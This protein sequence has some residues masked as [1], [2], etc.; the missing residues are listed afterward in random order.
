MAVSSTDVLVHV[1]VISNKKSI[2]SSQIRTVISNIKLA[3]TSLHCSIS[4][5]TLDRRLSDPI[6]THRQSICNLRPQIRSDPRFATHVN[7]TCLV[8]LMFWL[9]FIDTT[10]TAPI[11]SCV[12]GRTQFSKIV[13]FAGKRFLLSP[14][15]SF[16][17]FFASRLPTFSSINSRGNTCYAGYF[18]RKLR[19][20]QL[21]NHFALIRF[22]KTSV[23]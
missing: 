3:F 23:E 18:V 6:L 4:N 8:W 20:F 14:P 5:Y 9:L 16:L 12:R 19:W 1:D 15:P 2:F 13:G 21:K 11:K 10:S 17:F 22:S 7:K